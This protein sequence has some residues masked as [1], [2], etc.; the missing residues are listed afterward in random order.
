M[1]LKLDHLSDSSGEQVTDTDCQGSRPGFLI[2]QLE[3]GQRNAFL[4]V[5]GDAAPA[6]DHNLR[7]IGLRRGLCTPDSSS[8][9]LGEY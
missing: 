2:S 6:G 1:F 4:T 9:Y 5:P 3:V 8:G 7:P